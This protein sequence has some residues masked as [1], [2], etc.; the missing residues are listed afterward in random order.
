LLNGEK[1]ELTGKNICLISEVFPKEPSEGFRRFIVNF[2]QAL[3]QINGQL[4][5]ITNDQTCDN[6][7]YIHKV[8]LNKLFLNIG[9]KRILNK[10]KPQLLI[11]IPYSSLTLWGYAR[12]KMLQM[13]SGS[14]MVIIG[15]QPR[16]LSS[17]KWNVVKFLLQPH[18]VFVQSEESKSNLQVNGLKSVE[19][20]DSGVELEKFKGVHPEIKTAL[21]AKYGVDQNKYV[22]LH[23]GHLKIGRNIR[24]LIQL[25]KNP[26]NTVLM[27]CSPDTTSDIELQKQLE[28][29]K[30]QIISQYLPNIEEIYQISDLYYFPV[31][32][33]TESIEM[34]LSVLEA[35]G[36][37]IPVLTTEFGGLKRLAGRPGVY[38][39]NNESD[40]SGQVELIK[41]QK[42]TDIS[43][44]SQFSW[45]EVVRR[46]LMTFP[47]MM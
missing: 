20:V 40:I 17:G 12:C 13:F 21:R 15:L 26:V 36:C 34:P 18:R 39:I 14:S 31:I 27:V 24:N 9:I 6:K 41:T 44:I 16:V 38:F 32:D 10:I 43:W 2:A 19:I 23:V 7:V 33:V 3:K 5:V 1:T 29:N 46:F 45:E 22:I 47:E 37:R 28:A 11:Y 42:K 4:T 30:V 8:K 25:A 35:L